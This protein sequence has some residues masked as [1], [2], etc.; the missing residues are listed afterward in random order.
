MRERTAVRVFRQVIVVCLQQ[1]TNNRR[2]TALDCGFASSRDRVPPYLR[3]ACGLFPVAMVPEA[4]MQAWIQAL[5]SYERHISAAAMALGFGI[6]NVAYGRVDHPITQTLL[7]VYLS[8]AGLSIALLHY[9][10]MHEEWKSFVVVKLRS[11]L[12]ALT[13]F[14]FGSLWSAFLVFYARSGAFSGS[15]P[16]FIV[17][18][19]IFLGNEIFRQY[20]ARLVFTSTLFFFA[21][22][23]YAIFMVPVFTHTIGVVTF[24]ISGAAALLV[25]VILLGLV[26]RL[27]KYALGRWRWQI[28]GGS[29]A[30]FGVVNALYFLNVL[31]P[32]PL[33]LQKT[34]LFHSIKR[35][36]SVYVATGEAPSWTAWLGF[37]PLIHAEPGEPIYVYSAVFAPIRLSTVIVHHWQRYD[38]ATGEWRTVQRVKYA[39][40]GGRQKGY[41][42][43]TKKT[44]PREGLWRV[45]IDLEDG[46]MIGRTE[47]TVIR[48]E[49]PS[50]QKTILD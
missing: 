18:G 33:A 37:P 32:L 47:F 42:G 28:L 50:L 25:F 11:Y 49:V 13:Q 16:F 43:Y 7:V 12:P 35:T 21:L 39:I 27:S 3:A 22:L 26:N 8:V 23:S 31:P 19:A 14:M 48:D 15:W 29:L 40:L 4:L 5:K 30:V 45:D 9:L 24:L 38:S 17:L 1:D 36:G 20:H 6:D 44:S 46:R 41:R 10:M 2:R 34:G